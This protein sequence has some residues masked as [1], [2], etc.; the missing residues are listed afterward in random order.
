[1]SD[2]ELPNLVVTETRRPLKWW[3]PGEDVLNIPNGPINVE[4][5]N[6]PM[7]TIVRSTPEETP[8]GNSSK[9]RFLRT[10][11]PYASNIPWW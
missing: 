8:A 4:P 2:I 1:M 11:R 3:N 9:P 6:G 10:S 7:P 5:Y